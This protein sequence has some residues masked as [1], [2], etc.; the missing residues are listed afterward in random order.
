MALKKLAHY[1]SKL[2]VAAT[3]ELSS[4]SLQLESKLAK[5]LPS[6]SSC[7]KTIRDNTEGWAK[8]DWAFLLMIIDLH[9]ALYL[10]QGNA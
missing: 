5:S 2:K 4:N 1:K 6:L 8:Q 9:E 7:K 3:S 10:L